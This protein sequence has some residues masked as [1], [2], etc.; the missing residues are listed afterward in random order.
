M[1]GMGIDRDP[2]SGQSFSDEQIN[3]AQRLIHALEQKHIGEE[4][5]PDATSGFVN[6]WEMMTELEKIASAKADDKPYSTKVAL[7][8]AAS[9]RNAEIVEAII[10]Q[11]FLRALSDLEQAPEGAGRLRA[12]ADEAE[13]SLGTMLSAQVTKGPQYEI[14]RSGQTR[15]ELVTV[16]VSIIKVLAEQMAGRPAPD[17]L[18]TGLIG[19]AGELAARIMERATYPNGHVAFIKELEAIAKDAWIL[20]SEGFDEDMRIGLRDVVEKVEASCRRIPRERGRGNLYSPGVAT[21]TNKKRK[22]NERRKDRKDGKKPVERRPKDFCA[23][24]IEAA[25]Q[26]LRASRGES[27][28]PADDTKA[29]NISEFSIVCDL[30]F[31]AAGGDVLRQWNASTVG[32]PPVDHSLV[33]YILDQWD[34][35]NTYGQ[36]RRPQDST[37]VE[38]VRIAASH[39]SDHVPKIRAVYFPEP[40]A[41]PAPNSPS[42]A[43]GA[44]PCVAL[45]TSMGETSA[46]SD[47]GALE[48]A[49]TAAK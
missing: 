45:V 23:C 4:L 38:Y 2:K 14:R 47:M 18:V 22:A 32:A 11:R 7:D 17:W 8:E 33:E 5:V 39:R 24:V 6:Q 34:R 42:S 25:Y 19:G 48:P 31:A 10:K 13:K 49:E 44:A 27:I 41:R 46:G 28:L 30:L 43:D 37:W 9:R 26:A 36:H 40:L 35:K 15:S 20:D 1:A 21:Q 16:D 3:A 12:E 29:H